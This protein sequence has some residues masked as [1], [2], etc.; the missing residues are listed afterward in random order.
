[1]LTSHQNDT[2]LIDIYFL[3]LQF[4]ETDEILVL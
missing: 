3:L 2:S 4:A 1:M